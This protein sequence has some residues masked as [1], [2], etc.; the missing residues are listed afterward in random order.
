MNNKIILFG[1]LVMVFVAGCNISDKERQCVKYTDRSCSVEEGLNASQWNIN[2]LPQNK[3][4]VCYDEPY[5]NPQG[6]WELKHICL[7]G[8]TTYRE[9]CLG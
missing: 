5:L 3:C 8:E 6:F 9:I 7:G 1:L 2:F 4:N